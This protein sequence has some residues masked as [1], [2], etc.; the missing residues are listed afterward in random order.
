MASSDLLEPFDECPTP[1]QHLLLRG[2]LTAA[3]LYDRASGFQHS[4]SPD[5]A[6]YSIVLWS[7]ALNALEAL[8]T[9]G[10]Q[11]QFSDLLTAGA[12]LRVELECLISAQWVMSAEREHRNRRI[13]RVILKTIAEFERS[14]KEDPHRGEATMAVARGY[15]N[16]PELAPFQNEKPAPSI[17]RMTEEV[18]CPA[19]YAEYRRWS[20]EMHAGFGMH[21]REASGDARLLR[22]EHLLLGSEYAFR[23]FEVLRPTIPER[24]RDH[25]D[26]I[27]G[28]FRLE[29][30]ARFQ[31]A[32]FSASITTTSHDRDDAT[33]IDGL[34]RTCGRS[35]PF[36]RDAHPHTPLVVATEVVR[37][38]WGKNFECV[39]VR[40]RNVSTQTV[41]VRARLSEETRRRWRL[42]R[43][44][45][46]SCEDAHF[47]PPLKLLPE[48]SGYLMFPGPVSKAKSIEL[49]SGEPV[50]RVDVCRRPDA[51]MQ[52][53][54]GHSF[55]FVVVRMDLVTDPMPSVNRWLQPIVV[56]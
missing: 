51:A 34:A 2:V 17:R 52:N 21:I 29:Y 53:I 40:F 45:R 26:T 55:E 11:L 41:Y 20:S 44:W 28:T 46:L 5:T 3:T 27:L 16:S 50:G 12:M 8:R 39:S 25:F 49:D 15:L 19:R 30:L 43:N 35:W 6:I 14:R 24:E 23:L 32:Y 13:A 4:M 54:D 7:Y 48:Q 38:I 42:W 22:F 1:F 18:G 10:W 37:G 33:R 36:E 56:L 47:R 31:D 9:L